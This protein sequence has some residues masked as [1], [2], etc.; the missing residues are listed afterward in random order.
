MYLSR[1]TLAAGRG[2]AVTTPAGRAVPPTVLALGMVSL[3]TDIS[4][5]MVTAFLPMYL[6]YG[7]GTGYLVLGMLDGLYTGATAVVRLAGGRLADRLGRPKAVA[8]AG[9]GLSALTKLG[10]P[11]A[12]GSVGAIGG[13]LVADRAGKGIRTGPRD[14]MISLASPPETLGR[15]FGVHR[16]LDTIGALLG[17]LVA[18]GLIAVAGT[19]AF[20]A[21]FVVSFCL[22]AVGLVILICYVREPAGRAPVTGAR[23]KVWTSLL[24]RGEFR[25]VCVLAGVLGVATVSDAFLLL[26]VQQRTGLPPNLLPLLPLAI[27]GTFLLAAIP[28]GRLADRYGRWRLFLGGHLLLLGVYLLMLSGLGGWPVLVAAL[29]LHGLFY[30]CSDGVLMACAGP[31]LPDRLKASGLALLQTGQALARTL[32]AVLFGLAA[33]GWGLGP[34]YTLF[35]GLLAGGVLLSWRWR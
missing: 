22:A 19:G 15:S 34:S 9:Y 6:I 18:F 23:P 33:S 31:L 20:D 14:A 24:R 11:L 3:F 16:M 29:G 1:T 26:S 10:F 2:G 7:L 35:S 32:A 21:V 4:A 17:P 25:R 12:G 5:E 13:L 28:A 30:A 27:A 8:V